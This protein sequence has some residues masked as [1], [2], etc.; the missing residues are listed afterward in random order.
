MEVSC[1]TPPNQGIGGNSGIRQSHN[2]GISLMRL[3]PLDEIAS[4][5]NA[6]LPASSTDAMRKSVQVAV[7]STIRK[8]NLVTQEDVEEQE[9]KVLQLNEKIEALEELVAKPQQPE[10][11]AEGSTGIRRV[12]TFENEGG[13]IPPDPKTKNK[14]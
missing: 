2:F 13:V 4:A 7:L 10:P 8:M 1:R 12:E 3:I 11:I 14:T 9:K 6:V 5:V